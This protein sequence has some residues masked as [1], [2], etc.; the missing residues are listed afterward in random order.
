MGF[1]HAV[2]TLLLGESDRCSVVLDC[3]HG[4]LGRDSSEG[5]AGA[6]IS[7]V[8]DFVHLA[9]CCPVDRHAFLEAATTVVLLAFVVTSRLSWD[10]GVAGSESLTC[11]K[12]FRSHITSVV[13]FVVDSFAVYVELCDSFMVLQ[14][15]T[16]ALTHLF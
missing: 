8:L 7:L 3:L 13:H 2:D 16:E 9:I 4:F 14:E 10:F 15:D 1:I 12:L 11:K 5:P 6:T